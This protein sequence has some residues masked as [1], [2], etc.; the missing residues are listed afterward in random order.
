MTVIPSQTDRHREIHCNCGDVRRGTGYDPAMSESEERPVT[1]PIAMDET[2][3]SADPSLPAFLSRPAGT[4]VYYGFPL[5]DGA[6]VDGFELGMITD[7]LAP[8]DTIGDAFVIAPDGSRTGLVW[9]SETDAYFTET[10]APTPAGG[11][12]GP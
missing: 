6:E 1:R 4:P 10:L 9:E 2:A 8:V 11:A 3:V 5:I 12:C 7:L